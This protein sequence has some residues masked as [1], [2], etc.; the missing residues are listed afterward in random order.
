[1]LLVFYYK[2]V[3]KA[4]NKRQTHFHYAAAQVYVQQAVGGVHGPSTVYSTGKTSC[5]LTSRFALIQCQF[6]IYLF[7]TYTA[8]RFSYNPGI[9]FIFQFCLFVTFFN[10]A[11]FAINPNFAFFS[12]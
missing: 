7:F 8:P 3:V 12:T 2:Y 1:M 6:Y 5:I 4:D 11:R 9:V 10:C